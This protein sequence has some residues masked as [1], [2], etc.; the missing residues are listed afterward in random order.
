VSELRPIV[1]SA[2]LNGID[3]LSGSLITSLYPTS[4]FS[5]IYFK[6]FDFAPELFGVN[7]SIFM[8]DLLNIDGSGIFPAFSIAF[9]SI[10]FSK[11]AV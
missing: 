6:L 10:Y 5:F 3:A 4:S 7:S 1:Y 2:I 9:T 11:L 8:K